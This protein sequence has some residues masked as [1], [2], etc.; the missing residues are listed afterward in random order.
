MLV[1]VANIADR[2]TSDAGEANRPRQQGHSCRTPYSDFI[3]YITMLRIHEGCPLLEDTGRLL[4]EFKNHPESKFEGDVGILERKHLTMGS[5]V[6][7]GKESNRL[8]EVSVLGSRRMI[9]RVR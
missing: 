5:K 7:I 9:P 1:G 3:D 2:R 8:E 4:L 6:Y